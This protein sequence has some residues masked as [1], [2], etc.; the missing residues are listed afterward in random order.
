MIRREE[1]SFRR[2]SLSGIAMFNGSE[3]FSREADNQ[4]AS[5][6]VGSVHGRPVRPLH[7]V[8]AWLTNG[9]KTSG[10]FLEII[11]RRK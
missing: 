6:F 1:T 2:G 11:M 9:S 5:F 7:L 3:T 8:S 10:C 4:L